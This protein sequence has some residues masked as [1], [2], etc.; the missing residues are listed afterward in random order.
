MAAGTDL[1]RVLLRGVLGS[2][3]IAHGIRH[4]RTLEGTA[5]WFGGIG[6][7]S[8]ELQARTSAVLEVA[9]GSAVVA[10]AGTPAACSAIVGTMT[11]AARTVH[12]PNGYFVIN[13]GYEYVLAVASMA[14]ALASLGPG[15]ISID[16]RIGLDRALSGTRIG[17]LTGVG[18]VLGAAAQLAVFWRNPRAVAG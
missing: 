15:R 5:R 3:M 9:A 12:V 4:G 17:V 7:R 18:G 16:H 13:E 11:V 6:F 8:P 1:A 10:G 2:T 14:I